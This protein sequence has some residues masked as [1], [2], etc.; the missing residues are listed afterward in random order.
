MITILHPP[1][2]HYDKQLATNTAIKF[3]NSFTRTLILPSIQPLSNAIETRLDTASTIAYV[4][5][6]S[7]IF[8][9]VKIITLFLDHYQFELS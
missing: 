6:S 2:E 9:F 8:F 3:I 1:T 4:P 7:A 5:F